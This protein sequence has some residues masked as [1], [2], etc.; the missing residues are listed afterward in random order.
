MKRS[1]FPSLLA[2]GFL[3]AAA[4]GLVAAVEAPAA[5]YNGCSGSDCIVYDLSTQD[6]CTEVTESASYDARWGRGLSLGVDQ[7]IKG[8]RIVAYK[9]QWSGGSWSAWFVPGVNDIDYKYN[10]GPNTLRRMWS[11]FYDHNH[12]YVLCTKTSGAY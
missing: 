1:H 11:Y 9:I 8:G 6:T 12:S 5:A 3:S 2:I 10:P 4:L 7:T